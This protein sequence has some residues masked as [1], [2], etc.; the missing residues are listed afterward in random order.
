MKDFHLLIAAAILLCVGASLA[1]WLSD[2]HIVQRF[3]ALIA[4]MAAL[5]V[6]VQASFEI[7]L[8]KEK[9]RL[10][11]ERTTRLWWSYFI[12]PDLIKRAAAVR[13]E[14]A[15]SSF[16]SMRMRFVLIVSLT[17]FVGEVVHG[18]GDLLIVATIHSAASGRHD[19]IKREPDPAVAKGR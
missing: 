2:P 8:E 19:A 16:V 9:Q 14:Q 6:F 5:F 17:A 4:G 15:L 11:E 1:W 10:E 12:P 3:G 18:F 7:F 13:H